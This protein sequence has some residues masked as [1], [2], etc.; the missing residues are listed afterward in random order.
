M[1]EVSLNIEITIN[2]LV[3]RNPRKVERQSGLTFMKG[4]RIGEKE[5]ARRNEIISGTIRQLL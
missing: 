4:L 2:H 5:L 3:R 1:A